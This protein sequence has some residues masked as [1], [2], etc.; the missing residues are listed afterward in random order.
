L[1]FLSYSSNLETDSGFSLFIMR[2]IVL[3]IGVIFVLT[4]PIAL[5]IYQNSDAIKEAARVFY[6]SNDRSTSPQYTA[7]VKTEQYSIAIVDTA[8]L[9]YLAATM[10]IYGEQAIVDP[11]VYFGDP[12]NLQRYTVSRLKFELVP[13]LDRYMVGLGGEDDFA[14]RGVYAVEGD[15]LVVRVS[16]NEGAISGSDVQGQFA[17]EDV[18]LSTA[19]QTLSYVRGTAGPYM[20][21]AS[22]SKI[23]K[24]IQEYVHTGIFTRPIRIERVNEQ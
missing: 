8:F 24:D 6:W 9:E 4:L 3:V 7:E 5:L 10:G 12:D 1:Y 11:A 16:L 15:T 17:L 21:P 20:D 22:L 19:L 14:G 13:L 2:R 23:E 18:F